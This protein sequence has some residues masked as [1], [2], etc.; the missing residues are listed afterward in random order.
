MSAHSIPS[1]TVLSVSQS[2]THQLSKPPCPAIQ[3]IRDHGVEGDAHA[4]RTVKHRSRVAKDP[5]QPNLRQVH[6]IQSELFDE[7]ASHNFT[8]EPGMMGENITTKGIDL[9]SLPRGTQLHIGKD[10][11]IEV[12]GLRN[13]C[14]QLNGLFPGLMQKLV[15]KDEHD[16]VIRKAGVMSVVIQSGGICPDDEIR[17]VLPEGRPI[18]LERV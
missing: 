14:N 11:I 9:L 15:L 18:P 12:T 17:V 10:A 3:L 16:R 5:N 8:I 7:L 13:P 1:G 6:L 4:G 2:S